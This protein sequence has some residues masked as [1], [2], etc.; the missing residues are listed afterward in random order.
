MS[1]ISTDL[2][3][4][5]KRQEV[6]EEI[7]A[8]KERFPSARILNR[9]GLAFKRNGPG[10]WLSIVILLNFILLSPWVIIGLLLNEFEA[11]F[12]YESVF[13][14]EL[15]ILGFII[16]NAVIQFVFTSSAD[17]LVENINNIEDLSKMLDWLQQP[18]SWQNMLT[19]ILP[20]CVVWVISTRPIEYGGVGALIS[21]VLVGTIIGIFVH[22]YAWGLPFVYCLKAYNYHMNTFS[23]ADSEIIN[24]ISEIFSRCIFNNCICGYSLTCQ[25]RYIFLKF[26]T[27]TINRYGF[28][29]CIN[30][31]SMNPNFFIFHFDSLHPKYDNKLCQ[32]EDAQPYQRQDECHRSDR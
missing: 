13:F 6:R 22:A 28:K 30:N 29:Y 5:Q 9:L 17:R 7:L 32:M 26:F 23:P 24:D 21:S 31:I 25:C 16:G 15:F 20:M 2:E 12:F 14:I 19:I 1:N 18:W 27:G 8:L 4:I 3:L 10:Y 11:V